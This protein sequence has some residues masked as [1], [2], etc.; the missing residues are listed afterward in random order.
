VAATKSIFITGAGSGMGRA[1][2]EHFHARGWRVVNFKAV[3]TGAYGSLPYLRKT[4]R[5]LMFSTSSSSATYG[6]PQ[7]EVYSATKHA[8]KGL[9]EALGIEWKRHGVQVADVL[10]GLIDTAILVDP[11]NHSNGN[12]P[13]S[14]ADVAAAAPKNGMFRLMPASSVAEAAWAAYHDQKR[15]HWYVP[16]SIG[17]IDRMNGISAEL[18]RGRIVKALPGLAD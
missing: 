10:L 3:L 13:S 6:M 15:L 16:A 5:S 14:S 2:A 11:P 17:W 7:T 12:P 9:T 1:G 18:V 8:I 4:T